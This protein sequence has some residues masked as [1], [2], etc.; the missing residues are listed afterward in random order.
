MTRFDVVLRKE[1]GKEERYEVG[2]KGLVIGRAPEADII[3]L[4]SMI[5]RR[6]ARVLCEDDA[7]VIED[8]ESRNGILIRG[9][10]VEKGTLLPGEEFAIGPYIFAIARH[11]FIEDDTQTMISFENATHLYES[12]ISQSGSPRLP[13][14][15]R[16]AQLVGIVSDQDELLAKVLDI[17]FEALPARRGFVVTFDTND[18]APQLR[19]TL[20]R[21]VQAEEPPISM[22]LV[23]YVLDHRSAVLTRN[24]QNDE[25]FAAAESIV[26]HGIQGAMCAPLCG[27][28]SIVGAIYVDSGDRTS[29][30]SNDDLELLTALGR[31]VGMAVENVAMQFK[32]IEKERLAAIGQA[33]A[34]LGHCMKNIL[35]GVKGGSQLVD[36]AI[37]KKDWNRLEKDWQVMRRAVDRLE[38][39]V[40]NLLTFSHE[41]KPELMPTSFN[42]IVGEVVEMMRPRAEKEKVALSFERGE[43]SIILADGREMYRVLLNLATNAI[44]A[45]ESRGGSVTFATRQDSAGVYVD[46]Q[47]TGIGIPPEIKNRLAQA[48]VTTK[49]SRGTGLGLACCYKIVREHGGGI[50]VESEVGKGATFTIFLP[51]R[52]ESSKV[53]GEE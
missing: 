25:R 47:D 21:G 7:L 39:L 1:G 49:G 13:F 36:I 50:S 46:I 11:V 16:A 18:D 28:D 22:T 45:C 48:F 41:K 24:A 14:L 40:M 35:T 37:E 27:Q 33:T 2:T 12:I 29:L 23:K 5:S 38:T 4:D 34:G 51:A 17:I 10:R 9:E 15:Y 30:F 8:L 6:H 32:I 53:K 19:A 44:D 42:E 20:S 26:A 52:G 3:L 43:L 31:V